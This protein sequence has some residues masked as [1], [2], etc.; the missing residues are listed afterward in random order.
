[1]KFNRSAYNQI[2]NSVL[3]TPVSMLVGP[4]QS[5]KSTLVKQVQVDHSQF[6]YDT[7]DDPTSLAAAKVDP[8][9]YLKGLGPH[10]IIDEIQR[11]PELLLPMKMLVDEERYPGRFIITGSANVLNLPKVA[12]SLA[13][14]MEIHTLWPLSQSEIVGSHNN[15]VDML[16]DKRMVKL[17][18][19]TTERNLLSRLVM[20]GF[21]EVILRKH[22]DRQQQWF[23]S[24]IN[25]LIQRDLRELANIE[26]L[27]NFPM[28]L[29]LLA[30]RVGSLTNAADIS[31]IS[32]ISATTLK[33]YLALVE[34]IF[35]T[36]RLPAW[37]A[38]NDKRIIKTPKIYFNDSGLLCHLLRL[39]EATL[40]DQRHLAGPIFENFVVM[41][42]MKHV[43]WSQVAPDIYHFR[44]H[45]GFEVDIVLEAGPQQVIGV[46]VK[47]AAQLKLDDFRGLKKL[48]E[49]AGKHFVQG[50]VLYTGA[51]VLPFGDNLFAVPVDVLW[52]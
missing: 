36:L 20:G 7:M 44:N 21:P 28:L 51:Q 22:Y 19:D 30:N 34:N 49:I 4:R 33:R 29:G 11:A 39:S 35:L 43:G 2:V 5:G 48:Q 12:D 13:G 50:I 46:E 40:Q 37:F 25:A 17:A 47:L 38:N 14:R 52:G 41:E 18:A 31:R 16:F 1:M 45:A 27:A 26:K 23:K 3:D 10:A 8:L 6:Y 24:Y 42:I 15:F 9:T 32:G